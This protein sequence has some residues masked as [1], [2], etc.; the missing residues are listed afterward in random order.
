MAVADD[1][2]ADRERS[3]DRSAGEHGPS[4]AEWVLLCLLREKPAHGLALARL[5]APDRSLGQIWTV[6]KATVYRSLQRLELLG[7]IR[8]IGERP[9]RVAKS[10]GGAITPAGQAAAEAWL[11]TPVEHVRDVRSELM[12][13]LA[14]HD[15]TGA[16]SLPLVRAQLDRLLPTAAG[17]SDRL[18]TAEGVEQ[19]L[20]Q[21]RHQ[22]MTATVRFLT[23]LAE[24]RDPPAQA[25]GPVSRYAV[26]MTEVSWAPGTALRMARQS[27]GLSQQQTAGMADVRRQAVSA[28]E[29]GPD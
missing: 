15:R 9:G 8:T 12:I 10:L 25:R 20:L 11:S 18:R 24:G 29:S 19:T 26:A 14:L 21:W 13:K 17:L 3:A 1:Q 28:I 4:L 22:A 23:T 7:L 16:D 27:R 6:P 2:R 5:L